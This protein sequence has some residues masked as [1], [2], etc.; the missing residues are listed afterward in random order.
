MPH[1]ALCAWVPATHSLPSVFLNKQ[2]RQLGLWAQCVL[3]LT[4]ALA[5]AKPEFPW[6]PPTP[7]AFSSI[8]ITT[9]HHLLT[10]KGQISMHACLWAYKG[11]QWSLNAIVNHVFSPSAQ[12]SQPATPSQSQSLLSTVCLDPFLVS[13]GRQHHR[14]PPPSLGKHSPPAESFRGHVPGKEGLLPPGFR[15]R[16][17]GPHQHRAAHSWWHHGH[18]ALLLAGG[19]FPR[20]KPDAACAVLPLPC[21]LVLRNWPPTSHPRHPQPSHH[22]VMLVNKGSPVT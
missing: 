11:T 1:T 7:Q 16:L 13:P 6:L 14:Y 22:P 8:L 10:L 19:N 21:P 18:Q 3:L 15:K 17:P 9:K 4:S 2:R 20:R 12:R 5:S